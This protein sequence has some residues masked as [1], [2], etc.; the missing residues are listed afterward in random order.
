MGY[1]E[2]P[3]LPLWKPGTVLPVQSEGYRFDPL[4]IELLPLT[5]AEMELLSATFRW[6]F[7]TP[8][9]TLK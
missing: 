7:D 9:V 6:Y 3:W 1:Q 5:E 8:L 4:W 2:Q